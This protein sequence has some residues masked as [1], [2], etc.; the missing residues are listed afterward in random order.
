MKYQDLW[1]LIQA[2]ILGV[3]QADD[4]I[5]T[6][7]GVLVEPGDIDSK[8]NTKLAK[9]VGAGLDGKLG[10]GF[11]VL[12]IESA[13]DEN[14]GVPGGALK[15]TITVQFVENVIV[16][17]GSTGTGF[18]IRLYA[19]RAAQILKLYTPVGL[20]QNLVP[21]K[22]VVAEFT[23]DTNKNL[24]CG[25]VEF[26]ATEADYIRFNRLPRPIVTQTPGLP[27]LV[28]VTAPGATD[29]FYTTDGSHPYARNAAAT[30][31]TQ[32]VPVT[33][34]CLFRV[35]SF[36]PDSVGSDTAAINIC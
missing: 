9:I 35:R 31:Y 14:P 3:L 10:V 28:T 21:R 20:T 33:Q 22:P 1:P 29:I 17:Q 18:P 11:L 30:P 6:R 5:G 15:L 27:C 25:N 34:P 13:E 12:P 36:A 7:T 2:D 16:N 23:D 32:P 24:R 8:I 19:A 4:F 26:Y